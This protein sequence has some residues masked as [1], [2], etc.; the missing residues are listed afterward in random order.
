MVEHSFDLILIHKACDD[1]YWWN[2]QYKRHALLSPAR[3]AK[4][5][6]LPEVDEDVC[7]YDSGTRALLMRGFIVICDK[8]WTYTNL[9][10]AKKT[11]EQKPDGTK[12]DA[13][14]TRAM[15]ILHEIMHLSD[16]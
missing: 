13:V 11:M 4:V 1:G 8:T 14:L 7:S 12:I 16:H 15:I 6:R 5:G 10:E 9:A 3:I 2:D